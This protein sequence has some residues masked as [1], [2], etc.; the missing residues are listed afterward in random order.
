MQAGMVI[1]AALVNFVFGGIWY[2]LFQKQWLDANHL[3]KTV[4]NQRD[5]KPYLI[6]F[7]GSL[8]SAYGLFII[9]KHIQPKDT[10]ETLSIAVGL[11]FFIHVGLGAK[12]YAFSK[13]KLKG[14]I[15]D[16]VLDLIGLIIMT[17][18]VSQ[19]Y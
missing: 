6:A 19:Y 15:I 17:F 3:G 13:I 14:F 8:W 9:V 4:I 1:A 12:H 16:Y 5:P 7:I 10:L 2:Y 11:W 18:M